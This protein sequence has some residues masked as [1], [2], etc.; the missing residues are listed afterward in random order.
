MSTKIRP[1]SDK[2]VVKPIEEAAQTS[3]GIFIPES[4]KE[5]PQKAEVLAVGPGKMLE[6]GV[7]EEMGVNVGD[8]ILLPKYGGSEVKI[9]NEEYK[10]LSIKDVLGVIEQ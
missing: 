10:I 3:G 9:D 5:K 8:F 7:R 4:S 1:L 2:I 6:S